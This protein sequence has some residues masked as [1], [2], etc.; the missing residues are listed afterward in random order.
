MFFLV[1]GASGV[2]KSTVRRALAPSLGPSFDVIELA[3]LGVTPQWSLSWRHRAVEQ[4][5]QR[6]LLAQDQG[7]HFLLCGDPVPPGE[8]IAVPSGDRLGRIHVCLLDVAR[9]AQRARLLARGD[10]TD[11]IPN[12]LAFTEWMRHHVREPGHRP[13]VIMT[14]GWDEMR[15][16]R[17]L[18]ADEP[19]WTA[20][21]IDTTD[22][23]PADVAR[24]VFEWIQRSLSV[25]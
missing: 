2:G 24:R 12:H 18:S 9:D 16:D 4:V 8:V 25:S 19:R 17:W 5:V 14:G 15:W 7:R 10:A 13:D 1:T 20:H 22:R 3:T 11:L 23:S 6:A 21:I